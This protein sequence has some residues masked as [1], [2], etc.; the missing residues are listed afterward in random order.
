MNELTYNPKEIER[1]V[2]DL[3]QNTTN[4][5]AYH[6]IVNRY[7]DDWAKIARECVEAGD[8]VLAA[9]IVRAF[10]PKQAAKILRALVSQ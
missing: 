6:I 8:F 10:K 2:F 3:E 7:M 9:R 5:D 1:L 4:F